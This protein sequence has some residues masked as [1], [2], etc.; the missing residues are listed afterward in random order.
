MKQI[1]L[2]SYCLILSLLSFVACSGVEDSMEV[3]TVKVTSVKLSATEL[4]LTVGEKKTLTATVSPSNATDKTVKWQSSNTAVA[5]VSSSGEVE[6]VGPGTATIMAKAGDLSAT[7][8]VTV[9]QNTI[10]VTAVTLSETKISM[11]VGE[12]HKL[13]ATVSPDNATNKSVAW[14]S[15]NPNIASVSSTGEVI[16]IAEGTAS[17]TAKCGD[18][19]ASCTVKVNLITINVTSI[20]LSEKQLSLTVGDTFTLVANVFPDN[21]TI[22]TITWGTTN[23]EIATVSTSGKIT[24]LGSGTV[25]ITASCGNVYSTCTVTVKQKQGGINVGIGSW[26]ENE[27]FEGTV[28]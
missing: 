9:K 22:K 21:A 27:S 7:C 11:T 16:A 28:K 15:S 4:S 18:K 13:T 23:S 8:T 10:E 5:N 1:L 3:S 25:T 17:I 6:A 12:N 20:T 14:N 26:G 19:S 2:Y 24:A